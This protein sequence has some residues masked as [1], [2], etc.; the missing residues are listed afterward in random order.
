MSIPK[1]S[2]PICGKGMP[3]PGP[4]EW[5]NWP[6]CSRRCKLIDLGRWL[7]EAYRIPS[8]A[9]PAQDDTRDADAAI[10]AVPTAVSHRNEAR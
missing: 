6:F 4:R 10:P 3:G 7:G 8:S 5:P 9:A 2:C 1:A